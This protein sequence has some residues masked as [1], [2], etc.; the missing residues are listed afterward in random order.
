MANQTQYDPADA[1]LLETATGQICKICHQIF[2]SV[3]PRTARYSARRHVRAVH[4]FGNEV[5]NPGQ[6]DEGPNIDLPYVSN[7]SELD[8]EELLG[9]AENSEKSTESFPA[10][11]FGLM[12]LRFGFSEREAEAILRLLKLRLDFSDIKSAKDVLKLVGVADAV[13]R[14]A[15]RGCNQE[16][17][18]N[19]GI[20]GCAKGW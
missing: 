20:Y 17:E 12:Y 3:I 13:E 1:D 8:I 14:A 11:L 7:F 19:Q 5:Q 2:T 6:A 9:A 4:H 10:V 16:G 15:C 18:I